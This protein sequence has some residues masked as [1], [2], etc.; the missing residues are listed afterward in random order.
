MS[1]TKLDCNNPPKVI[2]INAFIP[3]LKLCPSKKDA[4]KIR[5]RIQNLKT[6]KQKFMHSTKI[7]FHLSIA[8]H[9]GVTSSGGDD[10]KT[11]KQSFKKIFGKIKR[12]NS[13]EK[14]F[15]SICK[16]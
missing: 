3:L 4:R 16:S 12:S 10:P 6:L 2:C 11:P 15:E 9:P 8:S 1:K 13:G 5:N 7:L 14:T